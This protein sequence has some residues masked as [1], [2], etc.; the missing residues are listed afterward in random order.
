MASAQ[1]NLHQCKSVDKLSVISYNLHG[2]NQGRPG[3]IDLIALLSPD[4]I[5]IQE[6][7]LTPDNMYKLDHLS[8]NYF[9]FGSSAMNDRIISGP[10]IGRPFGGTAMII[11]K[12]LAS[13]TENIISSD[14]Y[15]VVKIA[16]WLL[17]NVYIHALCWH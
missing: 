12:N 14:R 13:V 5:M 16:N 2:L 10:L 15:T 4:V 9:V 3:I 8:D 1:L 17:F 6:H 7:W 11:K